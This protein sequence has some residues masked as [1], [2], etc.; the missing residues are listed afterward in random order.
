MTY[1]IYRGLLIAF[2]IS[3]L[4]AIVFFVSLRPSRLTSRLGMRGLK[5]QRSL[6]RHPVWAQVE[7]FVRW[8]GVRAG[9]IL[10]ASA[11]KKLDAQLTHAGD[12]LGMTADEYVGAILASGVVG[13]A[14]GVIAA[15]L[16]DI[17]AIWLPACIGGAVCAAIPYLLV[18]GARVER[19][20]AINRGLPYAIDMMALSMSAGLDFPSA[21]H[22]VVEKAR[23]NEALKEELAYFLQ[24]LQLGTTRTR[25]LQELA[26]RVPMDCVREF[27]LA[28]IQA[29]ERGNPVAAALELQA[30]TGRT[31][32]SNS[33]EAAATA[34]KSKMVLPIFL[35]SGVGLV[36]I[37]M[38]TSMLIEKMTG[39]K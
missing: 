14:A 22:Q 32:R 39:P 6:L 13:T 33:A 24:Q 17:Q 7:P 37:A 11:R 36:L 20:R 5:R 27:S 4:A 19:F 9:P 16:F 29:E 8:M 10:T 1:P 2:L 31:R 12:Y 23:A 30:A 3:L 34:M 35:L 38:P 15:A 18:D 26:A 21:V 25:A 28:L